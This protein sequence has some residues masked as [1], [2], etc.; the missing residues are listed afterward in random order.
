MLASFKQDGTQLDSV[1]FKTPRRYEDFLLALAESI[2]KIATGSWKMACVAA[3]GIINHDKGVVEAFGNL[4]WLNVPLQKDVAV[5]TKCTVLIEN[6]A[7]LA[8]LS[9]A[10]LLRP[11][12]HKALYI[13]VSTGIGGALIIDGRLDQDLADAEIGQMLFER[14][15]RLVTWESM[16]SGKAI[17]RR[18]GK[19]ASQLNDPHIWKLFAHDLA[20]GLIDVAAAYQPDIIIIGG[21]VGSH[22]K[23]FVVPLKAALESYES[24]LVEAP[25]VVQARHPEEAVIFGCY[26]LIK[27]HV[28][29]KSRP[30]ARA[31]R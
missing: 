18:F 27:D 13:T 28:Q 16:A 3:P 19:L 20:L 21:G 24:P 7:K 12:R 15:G 8:G 14:E 1:K 23:K 26:E 29:V 22:F 5:I 9:E 25:K 6:D 30:H 10:R 31:T 2:P 17:V 4:P 11:L